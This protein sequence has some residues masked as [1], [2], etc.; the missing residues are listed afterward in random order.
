VSGLIE[1]RRLPYQARARIADNAFLL[2][3][4]AGY[5]QEALSQRT[6]VTVDRI[7]KLE[8]GSVVGPLD[9]YVRLAGGLSVTLDDLLAGV[10]WTPGTV[11]FEYDAGYQVEFN[12]ESD[13]PKVKADGG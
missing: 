11:E 8:N 7:S 13:A 6:L 10:R 5:S 9:T 1:A 3:K 12:F 4:Q 2:R